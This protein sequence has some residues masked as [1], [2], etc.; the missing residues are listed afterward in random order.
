MIRN[1]K[2]YKSVDKYPDSNELLVD[3][4][5]YYL[6]SG[7]S[8]KALE[9]LQKGIKESPDNQS[10]YFAIGTLYDEMM[11]DTS[12]K[13]TDEQKEKYYNLAIEYYKKAIE[14][15]DDYFDALFNLGVIY[16]NRANKIWVD[17][18]NL[19]LS[20]NEKFE[21]ERQR[22]KDTYKEAQ[23][24]MEKAHQVNYKDKDV[25]KALMIIYSRLGM[26]DKQKEM[27]ELLDNLPDAANPLGN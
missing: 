19:P 25:I 3:F 2:F 1:Q 21:K 12:G 16:Y 11:Q 23:K 4:I 17:A 27:K 20:E 24:Y 18:G 10:Y 6:R 22:A 13:Y 14:L 5:N 26:H 8:E 15:K 9:K 7:E